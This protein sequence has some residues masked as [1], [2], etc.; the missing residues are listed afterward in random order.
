MIVW[1]ISHSFF[2]DYTDFLALL[3]ELKYP[4]YSPVVDDFII[5]NLLVS[6]GFSF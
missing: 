2:S 1:D 5:Y 3:K 4:M 6:D